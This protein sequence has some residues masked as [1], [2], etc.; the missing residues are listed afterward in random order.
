MSNFIESRPIEAAFSLYMRTDEYEKAS[1][2]FLQLRE[3]A[4]NDYSVMDQPFSLKRYVAQV[5]WDH[6][7]VLTTNAH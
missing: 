3:R 2:R 7:Q 1:S 6:F 4:K 5:T